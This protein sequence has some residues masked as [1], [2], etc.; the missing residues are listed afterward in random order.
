MVWILLQSRLLNFLCSISTLFC[1]MYTQSRNCTSAWFRL[2]KKKI[3]VSWHKGSRKL[4][5]WL[6]EKHDRWALPLCVHVC[7]SSLPQRTRFFFTE[8]TTIFFSERRKGGAGGRLHFREEKS[9]L[10]LELVL[11][12]QL[13]VIHNVS[14]LNEFISK[15]SY[16]RWWGAACYYKR[17]AGSTLCGAY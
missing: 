6:S 17:Q 13:R 8:K 4:L 1:W 14:L 11:Q 12:N 16:W 3:Q 15:C 10:T 5:V 9:L 7:G 2:R